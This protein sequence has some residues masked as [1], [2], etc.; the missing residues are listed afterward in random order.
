MAAAEQDDGLEQ[1]DT[2]FKVG[3][4]NELIGEDIEYKVRS[5]V[6]WKAAGD[7]Q[8]PV[9][10]GGVRMLSSRWDGL[11]ETRWIEHHL[12]FR[13]T[14]AHVLTPSRVHTHTTTTHDT[15]IVEPGEGPIAEL[16]QLVRSKYVGRLQ[17]TGE[18]FERAEDTGYRIGDSD[19]TPGAC[20]SI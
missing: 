5:C 3:Q 19:T 1:V 13:S 2:G 18:V 12:L 20:L 7:K 6:G 16:N 15:K 14:H 4:W 17:A 10:L 11:C 9:W 8:V